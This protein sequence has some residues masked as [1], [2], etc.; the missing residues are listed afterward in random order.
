MINAPILIALGTRPEA[1]KLL[2]VYRACQQQQL[3]VLLCNTNQHTTM[4]AELFT[5]F[6][7]QPDLTLP[8]LPPE[9]TL[10][11]LTSA[12]LSNLQAIFRTYQPAL[13]VVQGDTVTA[14]AA[15]LAAFYHGIKLAHVEAGLRSGNILAPYPEEFNR[16][17]IS[18]IATDHFAPTVLA[19]DNLLREGVPAA[20]IF[21]T[22]NTV[23]D[24]LQWVQAQLTGSAGATALA[25]PPI[26]T[27]TVTLLQQQ[28]QLGQKLILFTMHRRES[29]GA[30]TEQVF[31]AVRQIA[32]EFPMVSFLYPLHPNP[33]F[34]TLVQQLQ[35]TSYR[36]IILLPTLAYHELIYVLSQ[37]QYVLTD[38]GGLQEEAAVLGKPV[39]V[40]RDETDRPESVQARLAQLVGTSVATVTAGLRALLRQQ[41]LTQVNPSQLYGTGHSAQQI[42]TILARELGLPEA[43]PN[44][45]LT[46]HRSLTESN[47][48]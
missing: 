34:K 22:G 36:N 4:L 21:V 12:I 7:V 23:V 44:L 46:S 24:A 29:W 25:T 47:Q 32:Q 8:P 2:P 13:V 38:S 16:K 42:V 11:D 39:L 3:P 30:N 27:A 18:L 17:L 5:L 26:S 1:I 19:R 14:L 33:L 48:L 41:I 40:L 35:L 10:I 9:R 28:Q 37:V 6:A 43:V 45:P 15:S 20:Q 31:T